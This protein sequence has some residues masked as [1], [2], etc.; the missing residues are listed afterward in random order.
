[1]RFHG[2]TIDSALEAA[3]EFARETGAV[4]IHPFDHLDVIA[5]QGTVG[6]EIM[7]KLPDVR[8]V[9]VCTGGGGLLAG[10]ALAVKSIDPSVR[11]VGVQAETAAAYEQLTDQRAPARPLRV[12]TV[13]RRPSLRCRR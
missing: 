7:A 3:Q 8:T 11:V 13:Y 5:G 2:D 4:L 6:L 10:V 12:P 1:V 9:V